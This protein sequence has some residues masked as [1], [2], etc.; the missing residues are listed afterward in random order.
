MRF[1]EDLH[2]IHMQGIIKKMWKE[3]RKGAVIANRDGY[4]RCR[5]SLEGEE[6]LRFSIGGLEVWR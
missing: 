6:V 1:D 4:S 3:G 2:P 5:S